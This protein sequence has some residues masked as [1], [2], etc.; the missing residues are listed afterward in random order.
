MGQR[1][2]Q[3]HEQTSTAHSLCAPDLD[4]D[5][6]ERIKVEDIPK[7]WPDHF[8]NAIRILNWRILPSLKFSSKELMLGLVVN[9]KPTDITQSV[10]PTMEKDAA[11]QMA[12]VAQ[13]RLDSHAEAIGHALNRKAAFNKKVLA[14]NLGEVVFSKGQLV[15]IY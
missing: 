12:Y 7:T 14:K 8:D 2:G 5:E 13:Q 4:D 11:T 15:Q 9:M 10:T 6:I 1:P 3:G